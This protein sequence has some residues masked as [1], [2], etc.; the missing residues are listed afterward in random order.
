VCGREVYRKPACA[1][2][3]EHLAGEKRNERGPEGKLTCDPLLLYR[4]V[5][6]TRHE[7]LPRPFLRKVE[8]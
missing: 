3:E 5:A 4:E 7:T 6:K 8:L 2:S 1:A